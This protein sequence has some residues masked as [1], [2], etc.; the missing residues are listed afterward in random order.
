MLNKMGRRSRDLACFCLGAITVSV[1]REF[2]TATHTAVTYHQLSSFYSS[3][4]EGRNET[5]L[6]SGTAAVV[7]GTG[8]YTQKDAHRE[9]LRQ[10]RV[11]RSQR[12]SPVTPPT[13][14]NPQPRH[15]QPDAVNSSVLPSHCRDV[16]PP[17]LIMLLGE[18][19]SGTNLIQSL[20]NE[21]TNLQKRHQYG[22]KHGVLRS[23]DMFDACSDVLLIVARDAF[24]WVLKMFHEPYNMIFDDGMEHFGPFLR[25]KFRSQKWEHEE[26]YREKGVNCSFPM[27]R[28]DNIVKLR[29]MKYRNWLMK[30]RPPFIYNN[31]NETSAAFSNPDLIRS[32]VQYENLNVH[33]QGAVMGD[34]FRRHCIPHRTPLKEFNEYRG[35]TQKITKRTPSKIMHWITTV[36]S[37][38]IQQKNCVLCFSNWISHLKGMC[39]II[40]MNMWK[41][42]FG[43][44][45]QM[46][47]IAC[48]EV[49]RNFHRY[50]SIAERSW[51][52][53]LPIFHM[54]DIFKNV[55]PRQA[56]ML[57]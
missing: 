17:R 25:G 16:P 24:S 22:W 19:H 57:M 55:C 51:P 56:P 7:V 48:I 11:C 21:N 40:P 2:H 53:N 18:R 43:Q 12:P 4:G 37:P 6:A 31:R 45:R 9:H 42:T 33:G 41:I 36:P 29:T 14:T 32:F 39:F 52:E 26:Y 15:R 46:K 44:E 3:F 30:E 50:C 38:C 1:L 27:E 5:A 20:I 49:L 10:V 47:R 23:G 8:A 35:K 34:I 54:H 28:A 13:K